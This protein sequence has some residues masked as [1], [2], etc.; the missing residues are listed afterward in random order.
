M[1]RGA[2]RNAIW[3]APKLSQQEEIRARNLSFAF[4]LDELESKARRLQMLFKFPCV[5]SLCSIVA[6]A[7]MAIIAAALS[8]LTLPQQE[9]WGTASIVAFSICVVTTIV[10]YKMARRE[11]V[12]SRAIE[13]HEL[14]QQL[15]GRSPEERPS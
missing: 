7:L 5:I 1:T 13:R 11:S 3:G 2:I 10:A 6:L 9:M 14:S 8:P 15:T 12:A 4:S